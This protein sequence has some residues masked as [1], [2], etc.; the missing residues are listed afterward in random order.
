MQNQRVLLPGITILIVA[1]A[2][3]ILIASRNVSPDST[4][5]IQSITPSGI[6]RVAIV[7]PGMTSPFHVS[8]AEGARAQGAKLGWKVEVQ[9][10]ASESDTEGSNSGSTTSRNGHAG[11]EYQFTAIRG[12][13]ASSEG[14]QC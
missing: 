2:A 7:P 6:H 14:C 1:L 4:Q 10:T 5:G 13:C 11:S 12:H 9:A 3:F 8:I